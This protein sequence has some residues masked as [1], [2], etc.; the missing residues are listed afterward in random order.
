MSTTHAK[1]DTKLDTSKTSSALEA[2]RQHLVTPTDQNSQT[3]RDN[4]HTA[5]RN[6]FSHL[7]GQPVTVE[8]VLART[9]VISD[10]DERRLVRFDRVLVDP[11]V[12]RWQAP[13]GKHGWTDNARRPRITR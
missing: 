5:S 12:L 7:D 9:L 6:Y 8:S 10:G 1:D 13:S 4:V 2:L 3:I 11:S